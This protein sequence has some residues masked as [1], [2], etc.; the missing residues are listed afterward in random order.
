M[1][2]DSDRNARSCRTRRGNILID[3][4]LSLWIVTLFLP[5]IPTVV[6]FLS[7]QD[8][9]MRSA[10]DQI[11]L[12]QLRRLLLGSGSIEVHDDQLTFDAEGQTR[13]LVQNGS[14]LLVQPGTWIFFDQV[15]SVRFEQR[16]SQI[17]MH[18]PGERG[19]WE[20]I[21]GDAG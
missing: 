3:L 17:W 4:L 15:E 2:A 19:E 12:Q 9:V 21:V 7:R 1:H 6:R 8:W 5:M 20:A 16:Q 10:Q 14:W 11:Q 18:L 13:R